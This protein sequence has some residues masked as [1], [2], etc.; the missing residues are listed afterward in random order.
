MRCHS[1]QSSVKPDMY[2][3]AYP[4]LARPAD[5]R[6]TEL[7]RARRRRDQA[8]Q[9]SPDWDAASEA[10]MELEAADVLLRAEREG[11]RR[12]LFALEPSSAR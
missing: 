9:G 3:T 4:T 6:P 8:A 5:R 2:E 1:R 10:V 11:P 7:E 12:R